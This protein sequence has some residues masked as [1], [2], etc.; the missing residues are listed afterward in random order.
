MLR[1]II[2]IIVGYLIFAVT[3]F[4]LFRLTHVDPHAPASLT[5][6]VF[7]I[8]YGV[9]FAALGGYVGSAIGGKHALWVAFTIAA[10]M[11]AG[12]AASLMAT[13]VSWSPVSAL[14]CMVPAA[15]AG[16]WLRLRQQ[17]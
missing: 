11:A 9:I 3:A 16:G 5:F 17:S 1:T 7:A 15:V 13:G 10:I 14:V 12:A 4:F 6:E 2:G 8:V